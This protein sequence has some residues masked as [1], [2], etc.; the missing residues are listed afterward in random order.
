MSRRIANLAFAAALGVLVTAGLSG[1]AW[2]GASTVCGDGT[3]EAPELCDDSN[4][5]SGDGCSSPSC[6]PEQC[7]DTVVNP[8]PGWTPGEEECDD[9]NTAGDDGCDANCK[10]ECGNGTLEG[11]ETCDDSGESAT[12]D[13]DCTAVECGD[14]NENGAAGEQCDD[15]N[16]ANGDGCDDACLEE[17]VA[18]TKGQQA[19]I[20]GING[21]V[22]GV[23]KAQNKALTKCLKDIAAG[24]TDLGT[25]LAGIPAKTAKAEEK[26]GK[27][28][29]K[30]CGTP[31]TPTFAYTDPTTGNTAAKDQSLAAVLTVF[32]NPPD[33]A[34]KKTEKAEAACQAEVAKRHVKLQET[35]FAEANKAKKT[36]LKG[37][38]GGNPA[39]VPNKGEL[40]AAMEPIL[41][42]S[43][44]ISKAENGVNTGITK[45]CPDAIVDALF[46]CGGATTGNELALCVIQAAKRGA[47]VAV[48]QADDLEFTCPGD[49]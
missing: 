18:Q 28:N 24:K 5:V 7:G 11:A 46:D 33:V 6:L 1:V 29:D 23:M 3:T 10:L 15:G 47:C 37:G 44:K 22:L 21:N 34:D 40:A 49:L 26:T 43:S 12:C 32:G 30:K 8:D 36:A 14:G 39:P 27:T 16:T 19:C 45:K 17:T 42:S 31:N 41:T 4:T 2:A 25:C 20:N 48:E 9:G 38:K 35:W 13:D